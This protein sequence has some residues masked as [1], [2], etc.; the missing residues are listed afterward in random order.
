MKKLSKI[1]MAAVLLLGVVIIAPC[2]LILSEGNNGEPTIW[3]FIGIAYMFALV[4]IVRKLNL[5]ED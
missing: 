5:L 2:A 4:A 3:N 1:E